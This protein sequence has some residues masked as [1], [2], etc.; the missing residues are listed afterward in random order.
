MKWKTGS[1]AKCT[2]NDANVRNMMYAIDD[3]EISTLMQM[4]INQPLTNVTLFPHIK[5]K[6]LI[7]FS[8][9]IFFTSLFYSHNYC[10]Y[11]S[12]GFNYAT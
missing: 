11:S 4:K 9:R 7:I 1:I 12:F 8:V 10:V 6:K 2:Q 5:S 3:D